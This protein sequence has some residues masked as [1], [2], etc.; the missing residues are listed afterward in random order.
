M[1]YPKVFEISFN[2]HNR[3]SMTI[4]KFRG[5]FWLCMKGAPE[6]ILD[7]CSTIISSGKV[8]LIDQKR[9][10]QFSQVIQELEIIGDRVLGKF[11]L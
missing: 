6:V 1:N 3:Y 8:S 5:G 4:N 2:P 7:K 9:R 10:D 11:S